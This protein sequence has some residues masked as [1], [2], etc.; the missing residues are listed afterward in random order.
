[1]NKKLFSLFIFLVVL[2]SP[3]LKAQETTEDL[4][5]SF[6]TEQ[7]VG[8]RIPLDLKAL[9]TTKI[10]IDPGDGNL[11]DFKQF[12]FATLKVKGPHIKVYTS[13]KEEVSMINLGNCK[14]TAADFSK[15][16][17]CKDLRL[18]VNSL[19]LES[20]GKLI[21][22]LPIVEGGEMTI[23]Q[24]SNKNEKNKI[25]PLQVKE[26]TEK[27]WKV[28]AFSGHFSTRT[29]Y[30]GDE[31]TSVPSEKK[32]A[33]SMQSSGDMVVLKVKGNG[34]LS[35]NVEGEKERKPLTIGANF[36]SSIM[37]KKIT[38]YGDF[39]EIVCFQSDLTSLEMANVPNLVYLNCCANNLTLEAMKKLAESLPNNNNLQKRWVAIDTHNE[40]EKNIL[41]AEIISKALL[42]NW[43]VLDWNFGEPRPF[44]AKIPAISIA[45]KKQKGDKVEIRLEA[46]DD[47]SLDLG[48]GK[49]QKASLVEPIYE[50]QGDYIHI[51]G[52]ITSAE[53]SNTGATAIDVANA[54]NIRMID[55]S[56]NYL[57]EEALLQFIK[58]I[59]TRPKGYTGTI[60]LLCQDDPVERNHISKTAVAR[61]REMN[62]DTLVNIKG[63]LMP[64]DG[65][66]IAPKEPI[67]LTMKTAFAKGAKIKLF[68]EGIGRLWLDP[69]DG[70]F[71]ELNKKIGHY[72]I[73]VKGSNMTLYGDV[74][75]FAAQNAGLV[76]CDIKSAPHLISLYLNQNSLTEL[77]LAK[78]PKLEFVNC[79]DNNI[80]GGA[81]DRLMVSL[82][83][84]TL[85]KKKPQLYF[86][87]SMTEFTSD[88]E[89]TVTQLLI[90][91]NKGWEIRDFNG[92]ND[93]K[94][95]YIPL[96]NRKLK[97]DSLRVFTLLSSQMIVVEGANPFD[98]V[99]LYNMNGELLQQTI[100]DTE[101]KAKILWD[102]SLNEVY[103]LRIAC[104]SRL[105]SL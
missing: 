61:L 24:F 44:K 31:E 36:L 45:T 59:P 98:R 27:G 2:L 8:K 99:T 80:K 26:A 72:I 102:S 88:N 94:P 13:S 75:W 76:A 97:R 68:A 7:A 34:E 3:H 30:A 83:D 21:A 74:T 33:V 65:E 28:T 89:A 101:G 71:L 50:L 20:M 29:P 53:L 62:W 25:S 66:T 52:D 54:L 79:A 90:A 64:Y 5:F 85:W 58:T 96:A 51:F 87:D 17:G 70:A 4:L 77:L 35:Y 14:V 1:M 10:R 39:T 43:K 38:L 73:E 103:L 55:C 18:F 60:V 49:E 104:H 63:Q 32:P 91:K 67:A 69:G 12:S 92:G 23:K 86:V 57:E 82:A 81:V 78:A 42:K 16:T 9:E 19:S 6:T 46:N 22:S 84:A 11:I 93:E 41:T 37:N 100:A 40:Y 48:D 105:I 95:F 15:A 56:K 47:I